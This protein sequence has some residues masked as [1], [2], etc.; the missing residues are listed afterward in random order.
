[1]HLDGRKYFNAFLNLFWVLFPISFLFVFVYLYFYT[2]KLKNP[3]NKAGVYFFCILVLVNFY[4]C[5]CIWWGELGKCPVTEQVCPSP[6]PSLTWQ[7][8][9]QKQVVTISAGTLQ[10]FGCLYR[11]LARQDLIA[12]DIYPICW[13]SQDLNHF[14]IKRSKKYLSNWL[15]Y[16]FSLSSAI[17]ISKRF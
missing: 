15:L 12:R 11:L 8:H 13:K 16:L 6:S 3:C 17:K 7:V 2:K 14:G 10:L 4:L 5:I 9:F 1:M